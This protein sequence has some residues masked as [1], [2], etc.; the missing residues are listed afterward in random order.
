[1]G[2]GPSG[3]HERSRLLWCWLRMQVSMATDSAGQGKG[4]MGLVAASLPAQGL[5]WLHLCWRRG[6]G[7]LR[8]GGR[9][10]LAQGCCN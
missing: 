3:P 7:E 1:M 4:A 6:V 8:P 10:G 5:W 9:A 2:L